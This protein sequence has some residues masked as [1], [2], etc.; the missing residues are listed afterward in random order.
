M[1]ATRQL[2]ELYEKDEVAWYEKN[3]QLIRQN[4]IEL[5]DMQHLAEHLEDMGR[6]EKNELL[7]RMIELLMHLLKWKYQP[8]RQ[9]AS[10]ERSIREQR[11]MINLEIKSS[12]NLKKYLEEHYEDAYKEARLYAIEET[13]LPVKTFPLKSPFVLTDVLKIGFFP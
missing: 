5:V 10:W 11:R 2:S 3:A 8:E 13:N 7:T 9:G 12:T 4:K 6:R 1:V